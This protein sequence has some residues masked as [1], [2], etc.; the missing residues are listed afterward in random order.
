MSHSDDAPTGA[1][2]LLGYFDLESVGRIKALQSLKAEGL[3]IPEIVEHLDENGIQSEFESL[4]RSDAP[5]LQSES[6]PLQKFSQIADTTIPSETHAQHT[7]Q[8]LPPLSLDTHGHPAYMLNYNLGLTWLNE[9]ARGD[10][11][12]FD[13]P[14]APTSAK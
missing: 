10:I 4:N 11:F 13:K 14:P 3:S 9:F 2:R 8:S 5:C 1:A 7:M 6:V 12:S